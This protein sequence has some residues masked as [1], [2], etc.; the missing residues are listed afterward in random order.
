MR[1]FP[2]GW[3]I[4]RR[5]LEDVIVGEYEVPRRTIVIASQYVIHRDERFWPQALEFR[6]ERWLDEQAQAARPKFAYFPFGG[7]ARIC[8]GDAFAWAEGIILLAV[9]ARRWR[10]EAA[11][12]HVPG[13]NATVTLRP[14][15]GLKMI[16][17]RA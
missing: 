17:R 8:I 1:L 12:G 11:P 7:G 4:G 14:K 5:A 2:P 9:M 10:F 3:V 13:L 6:P 16:G 15:H